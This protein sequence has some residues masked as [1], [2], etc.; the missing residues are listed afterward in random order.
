[1]HDQ[2]GQPNEHEPAHGP[3]FPEEILH[4]RPWEDPTLEQLGH[5]PRS[6]YVERYWVSI[7][8]PSSTLLLRRLAMGLEIA[9]DGFEMEPLAWANELGLGMRGG[10]N[11]P[12]WR[13]IERCCRFN[14]TTRQGN[15]LM[16]RKKLAPLTLRQVERLPPHLQQAHHAWTARRLADHRIERGDAA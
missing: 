3:V 10:K 9:P 14:A 12:F 11:S 15:V 4:V 1:M 13:A 16:A 7:L 2:A 5:D 6:L 8:G